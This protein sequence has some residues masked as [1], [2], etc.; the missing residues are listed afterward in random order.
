[1]LPDTAAIAALAGA[2]ADDDVAG[3]VQDHG[4]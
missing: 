1:V 3:F 2:L 4:L